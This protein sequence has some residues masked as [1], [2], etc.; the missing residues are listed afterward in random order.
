[1]A[2]GSGNLTLLVK[3]MSRCLKLYKNVETFLK[4]FKLIERKQEYEIKIKDKR[5]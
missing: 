2:N 1:M 4:I 3:L 5:G